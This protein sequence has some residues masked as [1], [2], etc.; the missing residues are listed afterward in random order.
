[1]NLVEISFTPKAHIIFTQDEIE[2]LCKCSAAH[3]DSACKAAS[4]V[5]GFLYGMSNHFSFSPDSPYALAWR[6]LDT[7][8]KILEV[9]PFVFTRPSSLR[10]LIS[11]TLSTMQEVTPKPYLMPGGKP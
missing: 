6:E 3:Y 8:A 2:H 4:Q 10:W 9:E 1:M 7:L 11:Q 5:G